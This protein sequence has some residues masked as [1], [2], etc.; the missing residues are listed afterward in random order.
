[1][2]IVSNFQIVVLFNRDELEVI[3]CCRDIILI[4]LRFKRTFCKR[5]FTKA[6]MSV[7]ISCWELREKAT[8]FLPFMIHSSLKRGEW[9]NYR[10]NI[11]SLWISIWITIPM[12]NFMLMPTFINMDESKWYLSNIRSLPICL[13]RITRL[14]VEN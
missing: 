10:Q 7:N 1:M 9:E 13:N 4:H 3:Q 12:G 8:M 6:G 2:I 5:T 11:A 14:S